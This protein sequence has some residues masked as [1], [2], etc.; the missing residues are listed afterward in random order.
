MCGRFAFFAPREAIAALFELATVP[1]IEPRYNIAP[2]QYAPVVRASEETRELV[3]LRWGL[4]PHWAKD[5]SIGNRMVNARSE[6][7]A[8]KPAFRDAFHRRRCLVPA[9]GFYEWAPGENGRQPHFIGLPSGEPFA[10]AGLWE[11]WRDPE[12]E[13]RI[14]TFTIVTTPANPQIAELHDRMPALVDPGDFGIWLDPAT[15][16]SQLTDLLTPFRDRLDTTPVSRAVN[17]PR[18]EGPAILERAHENRP[19]RQEDLFDS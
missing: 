14:Q 19:A 5:V 8:T 3:M 1:A 15:D 6:T 9:N 11:S 4:V 16:P 17:D 12:S 7:L 18:N 2:T 13:E 10:M